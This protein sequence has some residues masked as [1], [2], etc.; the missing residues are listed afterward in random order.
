M[1]DIDLWNDLEEAERMKDKTEYK[2]IVKIIKLN[3]PEMSLK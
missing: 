3:Y 1:N 2:R